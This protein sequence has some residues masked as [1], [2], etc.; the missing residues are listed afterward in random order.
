MVLFQARDRVR[1]RRQ[2]M[3]TGA[4]G[5]DVGRWGATV[6]LPLGK[7]IV[8]NLDFILGD[9]GPAVINWE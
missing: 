7:G 5:A 4:I 1:G 8:P 9:R 3:R 2:C 6:K